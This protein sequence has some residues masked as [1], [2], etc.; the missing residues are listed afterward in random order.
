MHSCVPRSPE[1]LSH[2]SATFNFFV[3][4][5]GKAPFVLIS[6]NLWGACWRYIYITQDGYL[7]NFQLKIFCQSL[8]WGEARTLFGFKKGREVASF[9]CNKESN[10]IFDVWL[11]PALLKYNWYKNLHII[12]EYNLVSLYICTHSCEHRHDPGNK[13]IS[14]KRKR[15]I[16][17]DFP[18]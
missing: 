12:N 7:P 1:A 10:S 5:W 16:N 3:F 8:C 4:K 6:P 17:K 2:L 11:F 15:K 14:S 9:L 18:R 13:Y